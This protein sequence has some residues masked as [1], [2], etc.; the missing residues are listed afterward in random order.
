MQENRHLNGNNDN[1]EASGVN[2]RSIFRAGA[3]GL[4][5]TGL[6]GGMLAGFLAL[7][8]S[9]KPLEGYRGDLGILRP[10]GSREEKEFLSLC[11]RCNQC[12]DSCEAQC[13]VLFGPEGGRL[14]GTPY[15]V[16]KDRGCTLCLKC[17]ETCPSGAI[18][19]LTRKE[20]ALMGTAVVDER[21]CV[22]HNGTGVCG[23]CHTICPL[24]NRAITQNMH[25]AP[26]VHP[27]H[28]TGCGL[29]EEMCIVKDRRAIRVKSERPGPAAAREA[30]P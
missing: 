6:V 8:G 10:P 4:A 3:A 2:R 23:A 24:K 28:C 27:D 21:L 9:S 19:P 18:L 1:L 13:I 22:S 12:A 16:A 5:R 17:C 20:E 29:C 15:L 26:E 11:L 7:R 30:A 25:N 14:Q